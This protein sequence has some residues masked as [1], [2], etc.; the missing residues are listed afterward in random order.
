MKTKA[1]K[2]HQSAEFKKRLGLVGVGLSFFAFAFLVVSMLS[3]IVKTNA[4]TIH[5]VI[6][7][8]NP[9]SE[10]TASLSVTDSLDIDIAPNEEYEIFTGSTD[11][12]LNTTC[13]NGLILKISSDSDDNRLIS[14]A[15]NA[16]GVIVPTTRTS[17]SLAWGSWGFSLDDGENYGP[18]PPVSSPV[19]VLDNRDN[20]PSDGNENLSILYGIFVNSDF[21]SGDYENNILYT[22]AVN[23]KCLTYNIKFDTQGG[24]EIADT[25]AHFGDLTDLSQIEVEKQYYTLQY[26]RS[27]GGSTYYPNNFGTPVNINTQNLP[28][29][30]MTAYW[31][32]KEY[33]IPLNAN[34][35][36]V[37][38]DSVK[39]KWGVAMTL[40]EPH[41]TGYAFDGWYTAQTGGTKIESDFKD[42]PSVE[43][44][45]YAHWSE[46]DSIFD[47]TSMQ[48]M[49]PGIC[50]ATNIPNKTAILFD[51]DGTHSNDSSYVPRAKLKDD[52]DGN[53]YLVSRLAD[54]N[55]WMSQNLGLDLS[56]SK[57]LTDQD[58]N[59]T[60]I[61]SWTPDKNTQTA[62][63]TAWNS[64]SNDGARSYHPAASD[65]YYQGGT[66]KAS[67]PTGTGDEYLWEKAGNYYNATAATAGTV[68]NATTTGV[69]KDSICPKGWTLPVQNNVNGS[70]Y[71]LLYSV[72]GITSSNATTA[73]QL[74]GAPFN[75]VVP[76]Y[77]NYSN[78]NMVNQGTY[79]FYH[80][81]NVYNAG[82]MY[83]YQVRNNAI[84]F[85]TNTYK[86]IGAS[87]R[88]I[89]IK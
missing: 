18:V 6:D 74:R 54:G 45:L 19:T 79:S 56:T 85:S 39:G 72:Y 76:G 69:A 36:S 68:T 1:I 26:W 42:W 20:V 64:T 86:G 88:C 60:T 40:P 77:L 65:A 5:H 31:T 3:P 41:R 16:V 50:Q 61:T 63:G 47:I 70:F 4:A 37:S 46:S 81:A 9:D 78:G 30:T 75:Y 8:T 59:L 2:T 51:T 87:I 32:L 25:F 11:I 71:Y 52:R 13:P 34:G 84:A 80:T 62:M 17:G 21:V 23:E 58:T 43:E 57:T 89:A 35:G 28:E 24:T 7:V 27:S 66:T 12:S 22:L 48:E 73:A 10:Y 33:T 53:Y 29:V 38:A 14:R 49:T 55:C 44:G 83:Y 15:T 82:Y 67:S